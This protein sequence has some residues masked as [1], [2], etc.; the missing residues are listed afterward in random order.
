MFVYFIS[1]LKA[2]TNIEQIS[3]L[4]TQTQGGR[5]EGT[6]ESTQLWRHPKG[7]N[8]IFNVYSSN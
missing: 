6:D 3:V 2:N 8:L 7:L 4:R 1:F 5:M